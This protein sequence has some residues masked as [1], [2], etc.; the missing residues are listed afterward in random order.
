MA[1]A[2][3]KT[4]V[5]VESQQ[6]FKYI[7][8]Q[9][10]GLNSPFEEVLEL[11]RSETQKAITKQVDPNAEIQFEVDF[12]NKAVNM[13]N[14]NGEVI[15]DE[16]ISEDDEPQVLSEDD[17]LAKI[18]T[19]P[20]SE[21]RKNDSNVQVDDV[22]RIQFKFAGLS[23]KLRRA[24]TSGVKQSLNLTNKSKV[25]EKYSKM[26]GQKVPAVVLKHLSNNSYNVMLEDKQTA[27]LPGAKKPKNLKLNLGQKIMVYVDSINPE[28]RLSIVTVSLNSTEELVEILR[29]EIPEIKSGEI[30]IKDIQRVP[31]ERSKVSFA[32]K[33]Q[34]SDQINLVGSITGQFASRIQTVVTELDGEKIDVI[35]YSPDTLE[36]VK[37]AIAPGKA[38][39]IKWADEERRKVYAIVKPSDATVV[40]G[41]QGINIEL[42]SKLTGTR[43]EVLTTEE[44][45][46]K[47]IKF[48]N[49]YVHDVHYFNTTQP[50]VNASKKQSK[51]NSMLKNIDMYI[52]TDSLFED[53]N[54]NIYTELETETV[55]EEPKQ[56]AEEAKKPATNEVKTKKNKTEEI[57]NIFEEESSN[58]EK[59]L[60]SLDEYSFVDEID[61]YND[62]FTDEVED[63][64]LDEEAENAKKEEKNRKM[65]NEF[66][67]TKNQLKDFKVDDDL[68]N[69]GLSNV[70]L[71]LDDLNS[72]DWD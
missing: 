19:I 39:D 48:K 43:I 26:I 58:I 28:S 27:F 51:T 69:Y 20:L 38:V 30:V 70:K 35:V 54:N 61:K 25:V 57:N 44:A 46:V 60:N 63:E 33:D 31:G 6:L 50:K 11:F 4:Q 32:L 71:D 72:D 1:K 52:D 68:T 40:I 41:K 37:N 65:L 55:V 7:E 24:I 36:Y 15:E 5:D 10:E 12:D 66:K 18:Y 67:R 29:N 16:E 42:A 17:A 9:A 21:A 56:K 22:V 47:G 64:T 45:L 13:F 8:L 34:D 23:D 62:E 3:N 49:D 14:L 53:F 2:K 59:L